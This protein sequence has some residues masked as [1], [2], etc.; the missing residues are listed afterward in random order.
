MKNTG[1]NN[2]YGYSG[3]NGAD[4]NVEGAWDLL[5]G[6][7]GGINIAILDFGVTPHPD[8]T[9]FGFGF[10]ALKHDPYFLT[11][12]NSHFRINNGK[13]EKNFGHGTACAGIAAGKGNNGI[14]ITG[15][16][17]KSTVFGIKI[18]ESS[19]LSSTLV[20]CAAY[21]LAVDSAKADVIS[22]S[23]ALFSPKINSYNS[24]AISQAINYANNFGRNGLGTSIFHSTGNG[25]SGCLP[26]D[27]PNKIGFPASNP[28]VIAVTGTDVCDGLKRSGDCTGWVHPQG[29]CSV[30][31]Y[32]PGT[33]IAAPYHDIWTTDIPGI[34][35]YST[36]D[37]T[38]F[39]G[40][41][42]ACP[43]VG[44]VMGLIYSANPYLSQSQARMII[45]ST[46]AK[47]GSYSYTNVTNQPNGTWSN[48]LGYG[49]VDAQQ[50]VNKALITKIDL[51][52]SNGPSDFDASEGTITKSDFTMYPMLHLYFK[53]NGGAYINYNVKWYRDGILISTV[54]SAPYIDL[55]KPGKYY[56]TVE[57]NC[58][59]KYLLRTEEIEIRPT[60]TGISYNN[61]YS[62]GYT[63]FGVTTFPTIS[64]IEP[65][66]VNGD[67]IIGAG[68]TVNV[69]NRQFIFGNCS[70]LIIQFGGTL[71]ATNCQFIGCDNW[72]GII[73]D[74]ATSSVNI[75]NSYIANATTG[76]IS[77]SG[78]ALNINL[79][80]F[81][82]NYLHAAID[83]SLLT[84][85][86]DLYNNNFTEL[87][88]MGAGTPPCNNA[89]YNGLIIST[90]QP[91]IYIKSSLAG[92]V[93]SNNLE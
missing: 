66:P 46:A 10:N 67:L 73:C 60:C 2:Y 44:G 7:C 79:S 57:N 38:N 91:K 31:S 71:N 69:S 28:Q 35:G 54:T 16:A 63:F 15:V 21:Y 36:G 29:E 25:T 24:F 56:A 43:I 86:I 52:I 77:K 42:A 1:S 55:S 30:A 32:G 64:N 40:T 68:A 80:T 53:D 4:I 83:G 72:Q 51:R 87:T 49:R 20:M 9:T 85:N 92:S 84:S 12:V 59:N 89:Y 41:S 11:P 26:A 22:G 62:A 78:G 81:A 48:E 82:Y 17:Y 13:P 58:N 37:Y 88:D 14:G 75:T 61:A 93:N 18:F 6:S 8:L 33:D 74:G 39:S 45:E 76:I 23:Y 50:A 65:V 5:N 90:Q 47:V 70:K 34:L 3:S 19:G 27:P